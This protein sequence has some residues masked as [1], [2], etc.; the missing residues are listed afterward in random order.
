MIFFAIGQIFPLKAIAETKS[1]RII[2][3][4]DLHGKFFP[5]NYTLNAEDTSGSVTQLATLI[6]QYR[7]PDTLLI[8]VGDTMQNN[9]AD[10]FVND[11]DIHPMILA[12]NDLKYDIWV[13]GN[14][15][16]DYGLD[17]LKKSIA[18]IQ[19]KVLVGNV[20][21]QNGNPIADGYVIKDMGGV[22]V[23]IIGML[24]PNAADWDS[25]ELEKSMITDPLEETQ[26]IIKKIQGK[27]DL[28]IGAYHMGI[29]NQYGIANSGVTDIL[30]ACPQF[31][32]MISSHQHK[33]IPSKYINGVL[34]VQNKGWAKTVSII[35]IKMEKT[36]TG[37]KVAEKNAG[38][39]DVGKYKPDS[40]LTELLTP[41]HKHARAYVEKIIRW[42]ETG[43]LPIEDEP[44]F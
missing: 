39:L 30:K 20:Y 19:A 24:T 7:T 1:I 42:L 44:G 12:L 36:K 5:Y 26:K 35:N 17:I 6:S 10:I 27:Y 32:V 9:F 18:D 41:Y 11:K 40:K 15:D 38:S 34:A 16:Y 21:D 14:H 31:D 25:Q 23:A 3:T 37:W 13:T 8:D 33:L 29:H 2:A 4:S 22:R 28:L 43:T